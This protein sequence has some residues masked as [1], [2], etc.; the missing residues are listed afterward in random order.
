M[1]AFRR[2]VQPQFEMDPEDQASTDRILEA[3]EKIDA[4]LEEMV[5]KEAAR[6]K[7]RPAAPGP[8]SQN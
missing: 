5:G 1:V 3:C 6:E 4:I 8:V 2:D 7:H